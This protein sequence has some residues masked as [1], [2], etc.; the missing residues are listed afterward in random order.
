MVKT[1]AEVE[2]AIAQY[3]DHIR[4]LEKVSLSGSPKGKAEAKTKLAET[5]KNLEL[6]LR[7]RSRLAP[8]L[9]GF[10]EQKKIHTISLVILAIAIVG[11]F[12]RP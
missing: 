1:L 2:Q 6:L 4:D 3:Q 8:S 11:L 12:S 9:S 5:K 7:Q 10:G